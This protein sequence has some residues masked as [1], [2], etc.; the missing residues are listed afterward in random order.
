MRHDP[1]TLVTWIG[2]PLIVGLLLAAFFG[3]EQPKPH[4]LVLISDRDKTFLSALV[5]HAYTQDKLGEIFTV[6]QVPLEEGRRR[7]NSGDGSALVIIPEGFSNAVLGSREATIQ[8]ITNPS[9]SI[10]P[11]IVESVTSVLV[12]GAWRLQQLMGDDL[13]RFSSDKRPSDADI[14]AASV[15]DLHLFTDIRKYLD[16]PLIQVVVKALEPNPARRQVNIGETMFSSMAFLAVLFLALGMAG[17]IWKE[18][19]YGTLQHV[20]VTSGS[21]AGFL[22]GKILALWLVFAMVGAVSL[23]SGRFL[24]GAQTHGAVFAMLWIA[25]CG[26]AMYVLLVLLNT[27][28][29]SPRGATMLSNLLVMTLSMLGGCFFP[30]DLMPE[31]LARIG[32]WMPNGWALL[33]FKE[34]LAGQVDPLGLAAAFG[35]VLGFTALLFAISVRR[36]RWSFVA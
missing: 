36:L 15:R 18:K 12:E 27:F 20:A 5:L 10:L 3:R 22:G 21:M 32:R 9:Q 14:A 4:G 35:A 23:L 28:F 16:P 17:D 19:A 34:I 7:I 6:Q 31:S 25:A 33:R 13:R 2:T 29:T 11:G 8:L 1:L 30:F 26:G 24:I